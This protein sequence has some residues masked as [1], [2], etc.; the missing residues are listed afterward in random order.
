MVPGT[1]PN[2]AAAAVGK[3]ADYS[4]ARLVDMRTLTEAQISAQVVCRH[5]WA[6]GIRSQ[7]GIHGNRVAWCKPG[8]LG[9]RVL[10][11]VQC[12]QLAFSFASF[13]CF[14]TKFSPV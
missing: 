12:L 2:M 3:R 5:R 8:C 7:V 6:G 1:F 10:L 11:F 4:K 14:G 13:V 9:R